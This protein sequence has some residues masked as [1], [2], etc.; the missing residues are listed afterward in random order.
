L[1]NYVA[2]DLAKG[3]LVPVMEDW[4]P[5]LSGFLSLLFEPPPTHWTTQSVH[6]IGEV[7]SR[8]MRM[9]AWGSIASCSIE[10]AHP[11]ISAVPLGPDVGRKPGTGPAAPRAVSGRGLCAV[12]ARSDRRVFLNRPHGSTSCTEHIALRASLNLVASSGP[13]IGYR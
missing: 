9:S 6:P 2:S 4:L 3:L 13:R 5:R 8:A 11:S 7:G 12:T 10:A 1:Y